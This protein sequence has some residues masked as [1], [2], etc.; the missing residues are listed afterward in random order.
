MSEYRNQ[1]NNGGKENKAFKMKTFRKLT[2]ED[3]AELDKAVL[4]AKVEDSVVATIVS[5]YMTIGEDD[6][7]TIPSEDTLLQTDV[8]DN[9]IAA[10]PARLL[11][12]DFSATAN[13]DQTKTEY[14]AVTVN[15]A[16]V[17]LSLRTGLEAVENSTVTPSKVASV[18]RIASGLLVIAALFF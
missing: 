16:G 10:E 17:D 7:V 3:V 2:S 1:L 13:V 8:L 11:Q 14:G 9:E 12:T 5:K 6:D 18:L 4:A 15:N